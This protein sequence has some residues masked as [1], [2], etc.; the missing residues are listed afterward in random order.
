MS[1]GAFAIAVEGATLVGERRG[2]DGVPLVLVHGFGG[3]RHDWLP[4]I[5]ALPADLAVIAYDQRGF[6]ESVAEQGAAFSHGN[7][8]VALLDA[9]ELPR[10][11]LCGLSL[12]GATV[13]AAAL[14]AS[15]RVRRLALVSPMLAGWSWTDAWVERWK[16]IG[17]AARSGDMALA[18]A[19]WWDHPLFAPVR[20]TAHAELLHRSIAVFAGRQWI[21]DDQRPAMPMVDDLHRLTLPT[22]LLTGALDLPDFRLMADL[23]AGAAPSVT[24]IDYQGAGHMLPLERTGA[25]SAAIADFLQQS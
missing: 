17:R 7:D 24:R 9:L 25:V 18:R 23:V 4:V 19:L 12:G 6:G 13:I 10:V 14:A 11:D 1:A 20:T 15:D 22:L 16:A 5:D 21:E 3:S 2:G 8:L